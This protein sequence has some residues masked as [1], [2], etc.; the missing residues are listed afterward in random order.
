[1]S[2]HQLKK[3]EKTSLHL[4]MFLVPM[5]LDNDNMLG[6]YIQPNNKEN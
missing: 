1:M 3:P 2:Y 5:I 6:L 4:Q